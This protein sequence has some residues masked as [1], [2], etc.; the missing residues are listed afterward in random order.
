MRRIPCTLVILLA[1]L[2][3]G[4]SALT[5]EAQAPAPASSIDLSFTGVGINV[6]DLARAE[7][8]YTEVFGL[9]RVFRF[10]P[11]GE[12]MEVGLAR[13]GQSGGMIL[14]AHLNDDPL[15]DGKSSYG[16]IV[17]ATS[18]AEAVAKRAAAAG[19]TLRNLGAP[20]GP[21]IIF[22]TDPDG[23]EVELYQAAPGGE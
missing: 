20:G 22:L 4:L 10:P 17:L 12:L 13:P 7:K 19:S 14:L 9:Q 8:F 15:P 3:V 21:V 1:G 18:D 23:Y 2:V 11:E 5:A 16:R 6:A